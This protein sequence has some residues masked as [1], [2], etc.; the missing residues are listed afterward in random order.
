[1]N[2]LSLDNKI[3]LALMAGFAGSIVTL[4]MPHKII[5]AIVWTVL[6]LCFA[7]CVQVKQLRSGILS[8]GKSMIHLGVTMLS[9][10]VPLWAI[11]LGTYAGNVLRP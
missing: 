5:I 11:T 3:I 2:N 10:I 6:Y 8:W 4:N 1:M 7:L 9:L